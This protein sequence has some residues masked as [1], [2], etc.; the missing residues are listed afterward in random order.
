MYQMKFIDGKLVD[1]GYAIEIAS[2]V[3]GAAAAEEYFGV[4][5][6]EAF[7]NQN[8]SYI[9]PRVPHVAFYFGE[10]LLGEVPYIGAGS[11]SEKLSE[12]R[13]KLSSLLDMLENGANRGIKNKLL[14][15]VHCTHRI[16]S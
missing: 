9:G 11:D 15:S 10:R 4:D 2:M 6:L 16:Y 5:Q 7:S 3:N 12:A 13:S 1:P 8:N 14:Y